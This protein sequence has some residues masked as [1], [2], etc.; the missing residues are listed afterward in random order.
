MKKDV[1]LLIKG[2]HISFNN[3]ENDNEQF[4][5]IDEIFTETTGIYNVKDGKHYIR[6]EEKSEDGMQTSRNLLK[7][8]GENVELIKKGYGATHLYF[9]EGE[10]NYTYYQTVMGKLFV[11]VNSK[12][13]VIEE[14]EEKIAVRIEYELIMNE[15]KVSDSIIEV[16]IRTL[17]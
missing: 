9:T 7:I 5:N 15:E 11:G 12:K 14:S 3:V 4:E 6:Y 16:K 2:T 8:D 1:R 17:F 10:T 13:I